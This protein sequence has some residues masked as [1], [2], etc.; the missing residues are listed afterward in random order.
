MYLRSLIGPEDLLYAFYD[1]PDLVRSLMETWRDLAVF[2][3][4][5]CQTDTGPFFRLFLAEDIC[6]RRRCCAS[7]CCPAI[8]NYMRN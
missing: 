7:F 8:A 1:T 2:C 5:R 4:K 6:S 3:L